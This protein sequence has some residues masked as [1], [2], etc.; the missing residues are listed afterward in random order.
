MA[1]L[2]QNGRYEVVL[3]ETTHVYTIKDLETQ[4]VREADLSITQLQKELGL[5]PDYTEVATEVLKRASENGTRCHKALEML[6]TNQADI[7][8]YISDTKFNDIDN[9]FNTM[10]NHKEL[11]NVDNECDIILEL[12]D[13]RIACGQVD[14]LGLQ[15]QDNTKEL[16]I[17]DYKFTYEIHKEQVNTQTYLYMQAIKNLISN[18]ITINNVDYSQFKG[19]EIKRYA[20]HKG[21]LYYLMNSETQEI[22]CAIQEHRL[23][24]QD[25]INKTFT[26]EYVDNQ[27][28][29]KGKV[30]LLELTNTENLIAKY[31]NALQSLKVQKERIREIICNAMQEQGIK[32]YEIGNVK[33]TLVGSTIRKSIDSKKAKEVLDTETYESLLKETKVKAS[34]RVS[35]KN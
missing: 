19:L 15:V 35:I 26:T 12:S 33:Y 5:T 31:E 9:T 6:R 14:E 3:N 20:N 32:S 18:S 30:D 4:E 28:D 8:D 27:L 21:V 10:L 16:Y 17:L 7:L 23:V 29:L 25:L 22:E 34:V 24:N 2:K 11:N 1:Y 13:G